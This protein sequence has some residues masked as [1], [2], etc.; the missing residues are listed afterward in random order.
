MPTRIF[1]ELSTGFNEYFGS[2]VQ[3]RAK[4]FGSYED[5]IDVLPRVIQDGNS[6]DI[7]V[8]PNS[9]GFTTMRQ[10]IQHLDE[11]M[12]DIKEFEKQFHPLFADQ[13]VFEEK[14]QVN[15]T[16]QLVR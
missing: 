13:L 14:R 7:F 9:G 10:Y 5:Y 15:G 8:V 12:I 1:E 6:P 2:D 11:D 16:Q 4:N 3:I